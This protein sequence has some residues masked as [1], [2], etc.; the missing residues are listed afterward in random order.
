[1]YQYTTTRWYVSVPLVRFPFPP[2]FLPPLF[3]LFPFQTT[4]QGADEGKRELRTRESAKVGEPHAIQAAQHGGHDEHAS[5]RLGHRRRLLD[6]PRPGTDGRRPVDW[7][8]AKIVRGSKAFDRD[9]QTWSLRRGHGDRKRQESRGK[10][11][12]CENVKVRATRRR[13]TSSPS[14]IVV[15]PACS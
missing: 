6:L 3:P 7:L 11:C 1:M 15:P 12:T 8:F 9:I 2:S 14:S 13:A 5:E 4:C 10:A